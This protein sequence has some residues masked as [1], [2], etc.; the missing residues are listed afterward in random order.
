MKHFILMLCLFPVALAG[1]LRAD[2]AVD[3]A[4]IRASAEEYVKAFN[5][6][7]AETLAGFWSEHAVYQNPLTG[8]EATGRDAI[9]EQFK[10]VFDDLDGAKLAVEVQSIEFLSPGVAVEQGISTVVRKA[11]DPEL[12]G[13]SAIHVK[14]GDRWLLDRVT[15]KESGETPSH[16]EQLKPLEWLIGSWVDEDDEARVESTSQWAKNQNYITRSFTI[17]LAGEP[18][19]SGIQVIGW[20]AAKGKIRSWAFD[21]DG[22][23]TEGSW[24]NKGDTW[25]VE[26]SAVLPDGRLASSI[27]IMKV[28]DDNTLSWQA[29]GRDVDGEILPNLPEVK[30]TRGSTSAAIAPT[31]IS[32]EVQ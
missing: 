11:A 1:E 5:A 24:S 31:T 3:E 4:A 23:F 20:D 17:E 2:Q 28:L 25:T 7:D 26:S 15:E 32:A 16:Y 18:G 14:H 6:H 13:Y 30:I 9:A 8:E 29:T 10:A 19:I 12:S 21:S 27:N 22:G